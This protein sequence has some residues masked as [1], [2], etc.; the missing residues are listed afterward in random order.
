MYRVTLVLLALELLVS[1]ISPHDYSTWRLE[2]FPVIVI[3]PF[4]W[5]FG[6]NGRIS[7][8]LQIMIIVHAGILCLGGHYTYEK[9]PLGDWV[10]NWG[11]GSRNNYDKVGHFA[12]GFVPAIAI[13]EILMRLEFWEKKKI[14]FAIFTVLACGGISAIYEII[15][16]IAALGMGQGADAFL[17]T[18]GFIWDT[19]TDMLTA[20]IGASVGVAVFSKRQASEIGLS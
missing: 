15:E 20:L 16:M 14:F 1:S 8:F 3:A 9:V 12:Q 7:P 19:Q 10:R 13:R 17:G 2:V 6:R 4:I 5:Y 18:Q 11:L